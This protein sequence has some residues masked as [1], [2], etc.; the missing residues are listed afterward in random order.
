MGLVNY[1]RDTT[2]ENAS[3]KWF[4]YRAVG[5]FYVQDAAPVGAKDKGTVRYQKKKQKRTL[6]DAW[7]W[8][9]VRDKIAKRPS[10][11]T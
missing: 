3:R 9:A 5:K 6:V 10:A 2:A 4:M 7:I 1:V 11:S 8:D